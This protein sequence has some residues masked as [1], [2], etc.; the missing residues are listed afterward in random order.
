MC[1]LFKIVSSLIILLAG[2]S[3]AREVTLYG[4]IIDTVL[5][6][7]SGIDPVLKI[8]PAKACSVNVEA[9]CQEEFPL[10][11]Y[12]AK[13][14]DDGK[15][16]VKVNLPATC[17]YGSFFIVAAC[18]TSNKTKL[19]K[20][21]TV[22]KDSLFEQIKVDF[23]K[24][25]EYITKTI[26]DSSYMHSISFNKPP[27]IKSGDTLKL[28]VITMALIDNP[29]TLRYPECGGIIELA[30]SNGM[31]MAEQNVTC[32]DPSFTYLQQK[33]SY[34]EQLAK[35]VIPKNLQLNHPDFKADRTV[36]LIFRV[37]T[38]QPVESYSFTVIDSDIKVN[39]LTSTRKPL[40]CVTNEGSANISIKAHDIFLNIYKAGNYSVDLFSPNG[41]LIQSIMQNQHLESGKHSF[42]IN[43][44]VENSSQMTIARLRGDG[45]NA[46]TFLLK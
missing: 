10:D 24:Q 26:R 15:F 32:S 27:T 30:I 18:S 36:K 4:T 34:F 5:E 42:A 7:G 43:K 17:K 41:R 28:S 38:V 23:V 8:A 31:I 21:Y 37:G 39:D 20:S 1:K 14:D 33:N 40:K 44:S 22:P 6:T 19:Y 29:D 46:S 12:F 16:S 45:V 11:K 2:I 25:S 9:G 35:I 13:T 3:N